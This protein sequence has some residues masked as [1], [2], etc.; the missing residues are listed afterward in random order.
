MTQAITVKEVKAAAAR[1][2]DHGLLLAQAPPRTEYGYSQV[3]SD[4]VMRFC[5]IGACLSEE[6]HRG[7]KAKGLD[8]AGLSSLVHTDL[9]KHISWKRRQANKLTKIQF[10]HDQWMKMVKRSSPGVTK[11][12]ALGVIPPVVAA[13]TA[14]L[15]AIGH[16]RVAA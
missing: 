12:Y 6:T 13:E 7:I 2:Y 11:P 8:S 9:K 3:C 1:A 5:A 16:K 4:G 15:K 14:F 10:T